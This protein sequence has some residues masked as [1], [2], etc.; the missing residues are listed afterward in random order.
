M[1]HIG[2]RKVKIK[3]AQEMGMCSGVRRALEILLKAAKEYGGVESLGAV[4]HNQQ[5][6]ESLSRLGVRTVENLDQIRSKTVAIP[7][8]G[9]A[10]QIIEE[11]KKRGLQVIDTTC[12]IVRKAQ[13][14]AHGLAK[15]GFGVI[16]FG[17]ANHSEVK[18]ILG[19]AEGKGVATLDVK[20]VSLDNLTHRLGI[21]SQTTQNW[22]QFVNFA[23]ELS[24]S[25]LPQLEEL[26]IINTICGAVAKRQQSAME[27]AK[28][29]DV[30]IVIGGKDS[31]NTKRLAETCSSAGA[32]SYW[33]ETAAE[34]DERWLKGYHRIGITAGTSTPDEVIQEVILKLEEIKVDI[35]ASSTYNRTNLSKG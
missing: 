19:W 14:K 7:S 4:V 25:L 30:V 10:P 15:A 28:E 22:S 24:A 9:V 12:P 23:R 26:R 18:G 6:V 8:H 27:L 13:V 29:S 32:I 20:A 3:K 34:I 31:A 5:V 1:G 17:E 33:V 2:K 21:L 11:L 16:V 35:Q